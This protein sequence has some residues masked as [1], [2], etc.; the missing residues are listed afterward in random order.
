MDV[1]GQFHAPLVLPPCGKSLGI[2]YNGCWLG[3]K[4]GLDIVE[5]RGIFEPNREPNPEFPAVQPAS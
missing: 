3:P 2:Y 4:D 5:K 1:S